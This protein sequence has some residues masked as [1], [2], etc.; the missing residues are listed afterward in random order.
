M[1]RWMTIWLLLSIRCWAA[2]VNSASVELVDVLS[3]YNTCVDGDTLRLPSGTGNWGTNLAIAKAINVIGNGTNNTKIYALNNIGDGIITFSNSLLINKT[4]RLC[5]LQ[6]GDPN[7][8]M[9]GALWYVRGCNTN[10]SPMIVS[11]VYT[12]ECTHPSP[13]VDGAVGV[14][15][16]CYWNLTNS[17]IAVYVYHENW[18]GL[19]YSSGSFYDP[20]VW[21]SDQFWVVED[22]IFARYAQTTYACTDA[23]RGARYVIR[24]SGL[25]NC[26]IEA[27]GTESGAVRG[28]RA[29]ESYFNTFTGDGTVNYGH[30]L[31]SSTLI[32]FSNQIWNANGAANFINIDDYRAVHAAD[33]WGNASGDNYWDTNDTMVFDSGTATAG[34]GLKKIVDNT[35]TWSV[36]QWVDYQLTRMTPTTNTLMELRTGYIISN[37]ETQINVDNNIGGA[38]PDITFAVGDTYRILKVVQAFDQPGVR[39]TVLQ[40]YTNN[41]DIGVTSLVATANCPGHGLVTGD[42]IVIIDFYIDTFYTRYVTVT[43]INSSTYQFGTFNIPDGG[44][45]PVYKGTWTRVHSPYDQGLDPCYEWGNTRDGGTDVNFHN[46]KPEFIIA[47]R[48]YYN[49]TQKPG[50]TPLRYPHPL[51]APDLALGTAARAGNRG[52]GHSKR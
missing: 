52:K 10:N 47:N 46:S 29:I 3:A 44:S 49:D 16:R 33:P 2:D 38:F 7:Q 27:H 12:K 34:T 37:T 36:N 1:I 39:D 35:K 48:H 40:G 20:I 50:Y 19:P 25:T 9:A 13:F 28:T 51:L 15:T 6:I 24:H 22:S 18:N 4:T 26:W 14:M 30:N 31:R 11:N 42:H 17:A 45:H 32:C 43:N 5:D 23:Y 21:G 41:T 8:V